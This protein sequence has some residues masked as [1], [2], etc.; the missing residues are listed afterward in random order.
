[1]RLPGLNEIIDAARA[2][3]FGSNALKQK[4]QESI[5][6]FIKQQKL[7][8]VKSAKF[9]FHWQEKNERRDKDNV[10]VGKKFIFDALVVSGILKND[11]WKEVVCFEDHFSTAEESSV[12][13]T[14]DDM[15]DIKKSNGVKSYQIEDIETEEL[16]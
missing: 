9:I 8:P 11:G 10:A 3:K 14:I 1:M 15:E 4:T 2:N 16:I 6:W 7:F 12:I 13:V 5:C